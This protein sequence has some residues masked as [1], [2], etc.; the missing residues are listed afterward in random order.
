MRLLFSDENPLYGI[1]KVYGRSNQ[2][3]ERVYLNIDELSQYL[4]IK[5][6]NLYAKVER[7]EIPFYRV[8]RLILFKKDEIDAFMEKCRVECFDIKKEAERVMKGANRSRMDINRVI[9]K[10]IE[11]VNGKGYTTSHGKPDQVKGLRKEVEDG[12]L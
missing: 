10:A 11:G 3:M 1:K 4:G 2:Q 12:T 7:R 8:G 6:S 9:K 5:K